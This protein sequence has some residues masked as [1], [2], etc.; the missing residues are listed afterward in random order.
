VTTEK[1][2][3]DGSNFEEVWEFVK[4]HWKTGATWN[5]DLKAI[6]ISKDCDSEIKFA[7]LQPGDWID[8]DGNSSVKWE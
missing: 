2:T 3:F 8:S 5:T 4:L 1:I 7:T 6:D